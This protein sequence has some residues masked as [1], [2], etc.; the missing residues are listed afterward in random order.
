MSP[1][2]EPA[3]PDSTATAADEDDRCPDAELIPVFSVL[4]LASILRVALG[5]AEHERFGSE[6]TLAFAAI[7]VLPFLSKD[8]IVWAIRRVAKR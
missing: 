1:Y 4:W 3:V 6:G 2:R 7:F 8:A 5:I